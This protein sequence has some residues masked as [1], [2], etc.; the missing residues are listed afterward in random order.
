MVTVI[1]PAYNAAKYIHETIRSVF[2][3]TFTNWEL[4]IIDDGSTDNTRDIV[5]SFGQRGRIKYYYQNNNGVSS[6]RNKGIALSQ[7]KYISFLDADDLWLPENLEKKVNA[8]ENNPEYDWAFSDMYKSQIH[9]DERTIS[10]GRDDNILNNLLLWEEDVIPT[11]CS[12]ILIKASCLN[13]KNMV[14]DT[15]LSTAADQDFCFY[16]SK[17]FNGIRI[18]ECLFIYRIREDSMS[19]NIKLLELDHLYAY[20]KASKNKLFKSLLFKQRCYANLY[21]TIAGNWWV[22]GKNKK[23]GFY[24]LLKSIMSYP[25]M[26]IKIIKKISSSIFFLS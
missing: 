9:N 4:I 19:R 2:S 3:Q 20:K 14:F 18:P 11:I 21:Y 10:T 12:N 17:H 7:G 25:P 6:A 16:L 5:D 22:N 13:K 23:R 15:S 1:I 8:L 26:L 24:F